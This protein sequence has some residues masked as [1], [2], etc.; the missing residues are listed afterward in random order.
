M[1]R[2]QTFRRERAGDYVRILLGTLLMAVSANFF[3][4]P[5]N[6]VPGGFTGLAIILR[7]VTGRVFHMELPLG[8]W[9][10]VLNVPLILLSIRV[11]GW[12]FMRRT[13]LAALVFSFW[14]LLLP[15]TDLVPGEFFLTAVI[16]GCLMGAG[17][18]LV[19][20]GKATTGGTDTLAALIQRLLPH[21]NAAQ[22]FPVLDG[23]VILL[24]VWIFGMEISLYA[25]ISVILSGRIADGIIAGSRNSCVAYIISEKSEEISAQIL[26]EMNRGVTMLE[27]TGKYTNSPRPV[28]FCAVSRKQAVVLRELV[29]EIDKSAFL[30]LTDAHE[31]RGE[32]FLSYG[33]EEF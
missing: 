33:R 28:L 21:L 22:I 2:I 18:G 31:V 13:F 4:E 17:L 10:I 30:I 29:E 14:L 1:D 19:F 32:G 7:D 15:E 8:L 12:H 20:L 5:A 23:A 11:R 16:G 27:G 26:R 24:S 9:N 3:Y 25:V 6:M